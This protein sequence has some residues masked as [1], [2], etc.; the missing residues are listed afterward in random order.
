MEELIN[1]TQAASE[2]EYEIIFVKFKYIEIRDLLKHFLTLI[3]A[4]LVF[5][6][7]FSEKIIDFQNAPSKQKLVL[8]LS[9]GALI[10]SLGLC[11][12]G[13]YTNYLAAE[14]AIKRIN[15]LSESSFKNTAKISHLFQNLSA[16]LYGLGLTLLISTSLFKIKKTT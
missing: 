2:F 13:L 9:W 5:S 6:V 14:I 3:S 1:Q 10:L 7:T 4:S 11:G 12:Y 15:G 8:Y 16:I